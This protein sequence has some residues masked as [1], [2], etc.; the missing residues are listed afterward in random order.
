MPHD[1]GGARQMVGQKDAASV[2]HVR[3]WLSS[4]RPGR[5][6]RE[7][8]WGRVH[9]VQAPRTNSATVAVVTV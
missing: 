5:V 2:R 1:D 4:A 6:S 8:E 7:I 3:H 9:S